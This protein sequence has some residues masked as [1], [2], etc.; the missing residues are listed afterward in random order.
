M[1][2][3]QAHNN[4]KSFSKQIL[5]SVYQD[6][7]S[8]KNQHKAYLSIHT[9]IDDFLKITSK[10]I[11]HLVYD[12]SEKPESG[13]ERYANI[14][15]PLA[16]M[17]F[18]DLP[19]K[20]FYRNENRRLDIAH[21]RQ[22]IIPLKFQ[23]NV[24]DIYIDD[25]NSVSCNQMGRNKLWQTNP[26]NLR[27]FEDWKDRQMEYKMAL[28]FYMSRKFDINFHIGMPWTSNKPNPKHIKF[29]NFGHIYDMTDEIEFIEI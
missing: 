4:L 6:C 19:D 27:Q 5:K 23:H 13:V 21:I 12:F 7:S 24:K 22:M 11:E 26:G 10:N 20:S 28:L 15:L 3:V 2:K 14:A 18:L 17:L 8:Q 1:I 9:S 16:S 29:M 25:F